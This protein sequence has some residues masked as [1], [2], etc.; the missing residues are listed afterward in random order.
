MEYLISLEKGL[1]II[2][3]NIK[4]LNYEVVD[5]LKSLNR[6]A[7]D[8]VYSLI[9]IPPFN[10]SA[11]DGYAIDIKDKSEN[12]DVIETIFPGD[13]PSESLVYGTT[14]KIM[15]GAKV[16]KGANA[17]IKKEDVNIDG[18][19][20]SLNKKIL[21]YENIC[22]KGEDILKGEMILNKN[23]KIDYCDIGCLASCGVRDVKVYKEPKIA[24]I[25]TGDEVVD[26]NVLN[27]EECKIYNTNK[28][29]ILA[30][31]KELSF[32][33]DYINHVKDDV[34]EIRREIEKLS[35]D[36]DLIITTGGVSVGDKD[37]II[38]ALNYND[39]NI[40]FWKVDIKPGSAMAFSKINNCGIVSLS[41][42]PTAALT[43]LE[44]VVVPILNKFI[45]KE[46]VEI[47]KE[48][49]ILKSYILNKGEKAR[50]FR[51]RVY[52]ENTIQ[53]V[54]LTQVKSGNGIISSNRNSNALI[55]I[56][57]RGKNIGDLIDI[58]K[59]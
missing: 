42:N 53:Y 40:V 6:V 52:I 8:D 59:L 44:L 36:Y 9:N 16:P 38:K 27:L 33:V 39:K 57:D 14:I 31:L 55:F 30:R 22:L 17:V 18:R 25:T 28:Y 29:S 58:I 51:G 50:F 48:K 12:L 21:L 19:L 1:E 2:N 4:K 32:K 20:I 24:L 43:S 49:A 11:M 10:K 54:E 23:K 34:L 37:L 56:K 41:G 46:K 35:K 15:T 3:K 5:I 47:I 7:F 13:K 45:G 26:L